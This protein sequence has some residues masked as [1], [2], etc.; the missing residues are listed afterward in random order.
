MRLPL[1]LGV[2]LGMRAQSAVPT[3]R[4]IAG[5]GK[6]ISV[7]GVEPVAQPNAGN[8]GLFMGVNEFEDQSLR[9]LRFAVND[10]VAQ[11]HLFI[12][13][14]QLV[15]AGNAMVLLSGEP[16]TAAT[17][18]QKA[19]LEA[20]GVRLAKA[21]R[22]RILLELARTVRLPEAK[23]DLVLVSLSSHGFEQGGVPYVMPGDGLRS[24]L[25]DTGVPLPTV[26]EQLAKSA[27]GKRL[28]IVDA[29]REKTT[30]DGKN[31]GKGMD[32]AWRQALALARGQAV[33]ASCDVGQFSFEDAKLGHG[34]FTYH[35][36]GGL[37]GQAGADGRGF[38]TLG[39]ASDYVRR[40]VNDWVR[41][42]KVG[43]DADGAQEPWFK[44]PEGAREIPLAIKLAGLPPVAEPPPVPTGP[45][46][47]TK[48]K[49]WVN[50]LGMKF[51]PV[52]G[53]DV[54]FSVWETRV[55]DYAAFAS[56]TG[57]AVEKP[58]FEQEP[59]HPVVNVNWDDAQA[60][61]KW[62]TEKERREGTLTAGQSYRL[63]QDWEWSVAV[64]LNEARGGTPKEKSGAI[65]DVYPWGTQWPPPQGAGNFADQAAKAKDSGLGYI[66]G[67]N[68]GYA[69]TSPVESFAANRFGLFDLSGN[70]YEWC[71]NW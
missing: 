18:A 26:E 8:A 34:V 33:L 3:A 12:L 38:I 44:G 45:A 61:A 70:A 24:F 66:D 43:S 64:G 7:E 63:P 47:A 32:V 30:V 16:G 69:W 55:Q 35:L 52:A 13:E 71:E 2:F 19:A 67:Y 36:L 4:W 11:A 39:A 51:V 14:L 20:A 23:S 27:A 40:G 48:E 5:D 31:L 50:S 9:A 42:N 68:D 41:R 54:L 21:T 22:S 1:L 59:T 58:T 53:T 28:L 65:K 25:K 57:R 46:S 60:F 6:G 56:A 62:L 10:A 49:P 15:P 17:R 29:C 37:R